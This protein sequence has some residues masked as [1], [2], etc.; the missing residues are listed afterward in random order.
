MKNNLLSVEKKSKK[1]LKPRGSSSNI[2]VKKNRKRAS[3]IAK[4]SKKSDVHNLSPFNG[5]KF[6]DKLGVVEDEEFKEPALK[7]EDSKCQKDDGCSLK[8]DDKAGLKKR[9]SSITKAKRK[10]IFDKI[11][12]N[13]Q[14]NEILLSDP[15]FKD[16]YSQSLYEAIFTFPKF[17]RSYSKNYKNV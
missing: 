17:R 16:F 7:N 1:G 5:N 13:K 14:Y 8:E 11:K 12:I 10:T 3:S 15:K 9:A 2:K 4:K 6:N